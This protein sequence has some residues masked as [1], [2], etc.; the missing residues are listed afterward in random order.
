MNRAIVS[1]CIRSEDRAQVVGVA[2]AIDGRVLA[3]DALRHP[4]PYR[5]FEPRLLAS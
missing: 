3:V 4:G 5:R 2:M 1:E